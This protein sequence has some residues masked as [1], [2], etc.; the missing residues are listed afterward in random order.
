MLKVPH[1]RRRIEEADCG[2][3][4]PSMGNKTHVLLDYQ[5]GKTDAGEDAESYS[6][7]SR[8]PVLLDFAAVAG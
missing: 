2:N 4:Q 5:L 3:A 7:H 8:V 1:Q 6:G